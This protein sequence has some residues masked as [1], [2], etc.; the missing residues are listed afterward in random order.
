MVDVVTYRNCG[1]ICSGAALG[2]LLAGSAQAD[3]CAHPGTAD[4]AASSLGQSDA[5]ASSEN[6]AYT[7]GEP[8]SVKVKEGDNIR[9]LHYAKV[10]NLAVFEGDIVLGDA[11]KIEFA[12]Q[13]GPIE[14]YHQPLDENGLRP[15]GYVAKSVLSGAQRWPNKTV[16][17]VIATTLPTETAGVVRKA[18]KVWSDVTPIRF[19]ERT[20]GNHTMYRNYVVFQPG[21]NL[22][23]CLSYGVGMMGGEQRVELV[24][25]C[26]FGQV[27]HEI[28]HVLGLDHEQNRSDRERFVHVLWE[29]IINNYAYAFEVRP[30]V[31]ADIGLYDY[32]SIMHYESNAFSCNGKATI[33]PTTALPAGVV[34]GQRDHISKGD[35]QAILS[36]YK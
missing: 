3:Q 16:P 5:P 22:K 36:V 21:T 7:L 32:D 23:A 1:A 30:S 2:L 12:A 35:I 6:P 27:V 29:N 9:E 17:F 4:V 31:Y 25:G 18:M 11:D 19:V 20:A 13:A 14:F 15:F 34:Y 28:G 26:G 8:R 24:P 10:G 33:E